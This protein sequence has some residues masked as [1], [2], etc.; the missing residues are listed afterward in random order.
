MIPGYCLYIVSV[1]I[2]INSVFPNLYGKIINSLTFLLSDLGPAATLT[3]AFS[4]GILST[5][6][7]SLV[8]S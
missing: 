4:I 1:S 7:Y 6:K 2:F 5:K 8:S 3:S